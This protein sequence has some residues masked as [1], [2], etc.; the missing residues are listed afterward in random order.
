MREDDDAAVDFQ[1][2]SLYASLLMYCVLPA[3]PALRPRWVPN[4][5]AT[6]PLLYIHVAHLRLVGSENK[7]T[8]GI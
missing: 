8:I 1:P 2:K 6:I 5:N 7:K 4:P 3:L